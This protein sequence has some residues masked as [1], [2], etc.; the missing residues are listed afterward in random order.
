MKQRLLLKKKKKE[1]VSRKAKE[2]EEQKLKPAE[3]IALYALQKQLHILKLK[4]YLV[5]ITFIIGSAFL[6]SLM[7]IIP[8]AEPI[9]FFA[10]LS[11][12][13]FGKKKGFITGA[14]AA[15][16][17]NFFMFGGQ[18]PWTIFQAISWGF[19]G[20]LG[21]FIKHIIKEKDIQGNYW[22]YWL[23]SIFP[24]IF[25]VV[26]S[27]GVFEVIMNI[28]WALLMPFGVF[29]LFLSGFPFL[30]IHLFS[31]IIF[32]MFLPLARRIVYEK[33]KFNERE[34]CY[35]IANRITN[36]NRDIFKRESDRE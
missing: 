3:R 13:L 5:I 32:A 27:T 12:W 6:R 2:K 1:N 22:L 8:S 29:A 28:S 7:Q 30:L 31:N 15:Y 4:E 11:G 20:F 10:I 19:A 9:T 35:S 21:G 18:G 25:I 23:K 16:L 34:I 24:V 33:G 36:C 14:L 26:F 17:S